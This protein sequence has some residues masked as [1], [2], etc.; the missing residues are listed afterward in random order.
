M[1]GCQEAAQS[2]IAWAGLLLS[3][4]PPL[5]SIP[6]NPSTMVSA[7]NALSPIL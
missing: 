6:A 2:L 4:K 7:E 3:P 5:A 1:R